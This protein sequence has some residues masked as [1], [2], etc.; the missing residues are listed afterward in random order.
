ME[1]DKRKATY[2][3]KEISAATGIAYTVLRNRVNYYRTHGE[4]IRF[5][6]DRRCSY[7]DVVKLMRDRRKEKS[8]ALREDAI[9]VLRTALT[10]D[11][12]TVK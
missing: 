9:A 5:D 1:I 2:S 10:H 6:K 3:L 4:P 11:G 8:P 12:Y 7:A